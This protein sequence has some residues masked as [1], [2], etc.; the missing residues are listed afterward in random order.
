MPKFSL[1]DDWKTAYKLWSVRLSAVG[2]MLLSAV[3]LFPADA[4]WLWNMM[5]GEVRSLLPE[6]FAIIAGAIVFALSIAA[7]LVKQN[8]YR[9]NKKDK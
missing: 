4:L 9:Y 6:N 7:R 1:I 2:A 3:A 5:P 8:E